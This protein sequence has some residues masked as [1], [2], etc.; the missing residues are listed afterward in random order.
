MILGFSMELIDLRGVKP[1]VGMED[2]NATRQ[3]IPNSKPSC[4]PSTSMGAP[5]GCSGGIRQ[6]AESEPEQEKA[7]EA[8]KAPPPRR[9]NVG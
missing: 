8:R 9:A 2:G 1:I 4:A 5:T 6:S 3:R 7:T